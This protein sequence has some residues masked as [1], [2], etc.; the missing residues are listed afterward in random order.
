MIGLWNQVTKSPVNRML[1]NVMHAVH[2]AFLLGRS[3][4]ELSWLHGVRSACETF[5]FLHEFGTFSAVDDDGLQQ[6]V[7]SLRRK[8]TNGVRVHT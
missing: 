5:G 7:S 6:A 2:N 4:A 3:Q 8:G 1:R